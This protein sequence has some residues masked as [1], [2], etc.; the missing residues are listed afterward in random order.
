MGTKSK[1]RKLKGVKLK[2]KLFHKPSQIKIKRTGTAH[3]D[4]TN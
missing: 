3:E 1:I 4:I 2:K